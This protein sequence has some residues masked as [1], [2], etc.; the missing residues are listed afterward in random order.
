MGAVVGGVGPGVDHHVSGANAL[1][2]ERSCTE[3]RSGFTVPCGV[4]R[5]SRHAGGAA[6]HVDPH[7]FLRSLLD[8]NTLVV[9]VRRISFDALADVVDGVARELA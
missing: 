2:V 3:D 7:R 8:A 4:Q 9:A 6:A 1:H 5:R